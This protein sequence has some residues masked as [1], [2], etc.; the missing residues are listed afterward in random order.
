MARRR[1][2]RA[3]IGYRDL[4]H[5]ARECDHRTRRADTVVEAA[6]EYEMGGD[7]MKLRGNKT[8]RWTKLG[9]ALVVMAMLTALL[10]IAAPAGATFRGKNGQIAYLPTYAYGVTSEIWTADADGANAMKL[11]DV[12]SPAGHFC[13]G[14]FSGTGSGPKWSPDGTRIAFANEGDVWTMAPDGTGMTQLTSIGAGRIGEP[15][16][17]PDGSK[18]AVII[19]SVLHI[20]DATGGGSIAI[21][22]DHGGWFSDFSP[23]S[24]SKKGTEIA[25]VMEEWG[26]GPHDVWVVAADGTSQT[27]ITND[28]TSEHPAWAP[29]GTE[30]AFRTYEGGSSI[31]GVRP[32]GSKR[33]VIAD[34]PNSDFWP[35]WSPNGS[36][37]LF[38]SYDGLNF[39]V[40]VHVT[41]KRNKKIIDLPSGTSICDAVWSPDGSEI[42][43]VDEFGDFWTVDSRVRTE[44]V[45]IGVSG[46]LPD[47]Q[48]GRGGG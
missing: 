5:K 6:Y 17:S 45:P 36:S 24:W 33:R 28:G 41:K 30:I 15:A 22:S 21:P 1:R 26:A 39:V 14:G 29:N 34:L 31:Q 48:S 43:F 19:E 10:S 47:W 25:A 37:L 35:Q 13:T 27:N 46:L 16:W 20:V 3:L 40:L 23:P 11:T 12:S 32:D 42:L 9:G 2:I 4:Q 38:T 8:R 44:P 7:E 18:I